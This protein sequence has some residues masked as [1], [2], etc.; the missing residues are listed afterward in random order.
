MP[1]PI[2][3]R[4][5]PMLNCLPFLGGEKWEVFFMRIDLR[6][7]RCRRLE[8]EVAYLKAKSSDGLEN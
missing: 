6:V 2:G 8:T 7:K 4:K 1:P 3:K 5:A